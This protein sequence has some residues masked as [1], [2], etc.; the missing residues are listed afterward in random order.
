MSV[1]GTAGEVTMRSAA[2]LADGV[3]ELT[4]AGEE[5]HRGEDEKGDFTK[6]Y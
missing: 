1:V 5:Y 4:A 2:A 3:E 6:Y